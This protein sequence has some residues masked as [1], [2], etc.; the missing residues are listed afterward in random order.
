MSAR[1]TGRPVAGSSA[2]T[3]SRAQAT[4]GRWTGLLREAW[5]LE[6][7][8]LAAWVLAQPIIV[9]SQGRAVSGG[10]PVSGSDPLLGL[11]YLGAAALAIVCLVTRP[12]GAEARAVRDPSEWI[13]VGPLGAGLAFTCAIGTDLLFG[14]PGAG[15]LIGFGAVVAGAF[16]PGILPPVPV[17]VRRALVVPFVL[18]TASTFN[19]FVAGLAGLFD[20]RSLFVGGLWTGLQALPV[21]VLVAMLFTGIYYL[22]LVVAPRE[23]A[24]REGNAL[25]WVVRYGLFLVAELLAATF[26]GVTA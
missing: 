20:V 5:R 9:R 3:S 13:L 24:E 18:L 21:L 12:S 2:A 25:H 15:I 4:A 10:F 1:G 22:M 17:V 14:A 16:L 23:L 11:A 19:V 8:L 26:L 7:V 6:D